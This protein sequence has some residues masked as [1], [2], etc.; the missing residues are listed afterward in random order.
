MKSSWGLTPRILSG[1]KSIESRWYMTTR[2]PWGKVKAGDT[3]YFKD[4]GK[5]VELVSK[6]SRVKLIPNL[7]PSRVRSLLNRYAA[8]DGIKRDEIP[9]FYRQFKGKRNC[10]LVFL[11]GPRRVRPFLIDKS[12]FGTMSAWISVNNI[13]R[14]RIKERASVK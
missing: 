11:K 13:N 3:I 10:M 5:P 12:G 2:P 9:K 14:I 1:E 6:V 4:S 8:E 7:S